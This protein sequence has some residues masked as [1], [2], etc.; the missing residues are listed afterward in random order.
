M[1]TSAQTRMKDKGKEIFPGEEKE[2]M[3]YDGEDSE[4]QEKGAE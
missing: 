2:P 4:G 3:M 1:T